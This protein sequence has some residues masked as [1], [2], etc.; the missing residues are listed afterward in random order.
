MSTAKEKESLVADKRASPPAY[1]GPP[2]PQAVVY[3]QPQPQYA[4]VQPGYTGYPPGDQLY[5]SIFTILCCFMPFGIIALIKSIEARTSY[6]LG[7]HDQA[8]AAVRSAKAFNRWA[9][10]V[11]VIIIVL[12]FLIQMAWIIPFQISLAT[13]TKD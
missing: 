3:Q 1:S 4:V 11:N 9:I 12:V 6:Q 8:A 7:H 13:N 2:P 5:M 10:I